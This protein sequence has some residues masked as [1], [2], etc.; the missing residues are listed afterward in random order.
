MNTI[1]DYFEVLMF[2]M[3]YVGMYVLGA[4]S[5][6]YDKHYLDISIKKREK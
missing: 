4:L 3:S 6:K 1:A 2:V 5:V